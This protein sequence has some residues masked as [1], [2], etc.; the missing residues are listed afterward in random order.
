[1]MKRIV[2][3]LLI[4]TVATSAAAAP[5]ERTG[6]ALYESV[7][8]ACHGEGIMGAPKFGDKK[9]LELEKKDGLTELTKDAVKGVRSMPPKGGCADCTERE[10]KAA[11]KFMIDSAKKK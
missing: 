1:M 9:W 10:I 5:K 2:V 6:K 3:L 11:V 8:K 7:C 4:A